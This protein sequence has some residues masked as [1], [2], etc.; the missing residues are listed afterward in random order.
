MFDNTT[1]KTEKET[2]N[3]RYCRQVLLSGGFNNVI[4]NVEIRKQIM[5]PKDIDARYLK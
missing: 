4:I 1:N 3:N 2:F 5:L